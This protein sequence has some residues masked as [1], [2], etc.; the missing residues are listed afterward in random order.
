MTSFVAFFESLPLPLAAVSVVG[1]FVIVSVALARLVH[2]FGPREMMREHNELTGFT[3]AVVG[4]IY[5]VLLGFIAIGVWERF[6]SAEENTFVEA[7]GL[8]AAYRDASAFPE[9]ARIRS[10]L[11]AYTRNIVVRVWP[12]MHEAQERTLNDSRAELLAKEIAEVRPRDERESS[13]QQHMIASIASSYAAREQRLTEDATGLNGVM[14]TVVIIGGFITVAF[15]YLFAFKDS[16]M[17]TAMIGTL[18]LLIGLV[19]F[20][21][22]SL[23]YPFRGAISVSPEAF[24][25][26]LVTYD[27]IDR[28][29]DTYR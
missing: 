2:R 9:A 3:F 13:L 25:R 22:M 15:T 27:T 23:D 21:T 18:A 12:A 8:M 19:I 20:L 17:Q 4:V 5:A 14:W 7:S 29:P 11:R 26:A 6:T 24:E 1:G 28:V 10:D 16:M